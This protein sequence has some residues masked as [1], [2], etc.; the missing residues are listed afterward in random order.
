MNDGL[1][2]AIG[3]LCVAEA[4]G[5]EALTALLSR[6][7]DQVT[8][9]LATSAVPI[10]ALKHART[11][12]WA[13]DY[14]PLAAFS[15]VSSQTPESLAALLKQVQKT[16]DISTALATLAGTATA[17][18]MLGPPNASDIHAAGIASQPQLSGERWIWQDD[19]WT[20]TPALFDARRYRLENDRLVAR[21]DEDKALPTATD[22]LY[23]DAWPSYE[24]EAEDNL[25][26]PTL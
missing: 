4:D 9:A 7:A 13:A 26:R 19:G 5:L 18:S 11:D 25:L 6:G 12:G 20:N 2:G 16:G 22:L 15:W 1:P 3:L 14:A 17:Q 8:Q 10:G 24:R 21:R 23:L